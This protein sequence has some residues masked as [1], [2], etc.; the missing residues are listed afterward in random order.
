LGIALV[1]ILQAF[2]ASIRA[3]QSA[4]QFNHASLLA[5]GKLSELKQQAIETGGILAGQESGKFSGEDRQFSWQSRITALE[6]LPLNQAEL[7][8]SWQ[9]RGRQEQVSLITYLKA[10]AE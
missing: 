3:I 6:G 9:K 4:Q 1:V 2:S 7:T 10:K 5:E 8:V